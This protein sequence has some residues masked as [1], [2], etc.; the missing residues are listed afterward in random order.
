MSRLELDEKWV[1]DL[2]YRAKEYEQKPRV[3]YAERH[4]T[5]EEK[6]RDDKF[7]RITWAVLVFLI[8]S[9]LLVWY[10]LERSF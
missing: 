5:D 8:S 9:V 6:S 3:H 2:E 7:A 1:A 4:R 10:L